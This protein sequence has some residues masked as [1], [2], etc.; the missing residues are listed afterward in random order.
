MSTL[1]PISTQTLASAAA[2]VSFSGIP[3]NYTDL[4][5]IADFATLNTNSTVSLRFNGDSGN[6]YSMTR[7]YGNGSSAT[8]DRAT[9]TS[10]T[11][12]GFAGDGSRSVQ[13]FQIQSYSNTTTN[14]T[15]IGRA[16]GAGILTM[17]TVG[18]WRNTAAITSIDI[19]ALSATNIPSGSTFTLY[20]IGSG[21]PKAFGGDIVTTDGT[22]WYHT[23]NTSG[24]FSPVTNLSN[25]DYLVVA[26]GGAGGANFQG[27]TPG[28]GGGAGGYRCSVTGETSG[29]N[30]SPE[31]KLNLILGTNYTVTIGAGGAG[32]SST[33][34]ASTSG[35]NS[36][37]STITS[38]GGGRGG[39]LETSSTTAPA[40]NGGSGGG[41][42]GTGSPAG[43]GT[44]N[45]GTNGALGF[46]ASTSG[47]GGGSNVAAVAR[48]TQAGGNG[49]N[50][51]ASSITGTSATRAGG[52][53]GGN[54]ANSTQGIGGT[55]G[56]GNG[57]INTS[58][59]A[60]T[61]AT[62]NTGSGGG[63]GGNNGGGGNGGSGVVIIRYAV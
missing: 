43:T 63:G 55:G 21:S 38:T 32:G 6:N 61:S 40:Q 9:N 57:G 42:R 26:G 11:Q 46:D 53:G 13:R 54:V 23:F 33:P 51:T 34:T 17:A 4:V 45:Q 36:V 7:L 59:S 62:V 1:T 16:D 48:T 58:G 14:K 29:G 5:L 35:S 60:G 3:Q 37:F 8:S 41:G 49:G 25:V 22:Y 47:G 27:N 39:G 10:S 24:V 2:S 50:G 19:L 18:L 52:G 28:G 30:S 56:A 44:S 15:V 31:S 12:V 20:G